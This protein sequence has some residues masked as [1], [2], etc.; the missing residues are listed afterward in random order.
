MALLLMQQMLLTNRRGYIIKVKKALSKA[1]VTL[2]SKFFEPTRENCIHP[3][4]LVFFDIMDKFFEYEDNLGKRAL[5]KAI[6]KM[7]IVEHEHDPYYRDRLNWVVEEL[8]EAVISGKWKP[9]E[10]GHP[11][12]LWN[13]PAPY[14]HYEGRDFQKLIKQ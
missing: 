9:R 13:E 14:G 7:V 10:T 12:R 1:I 2:A 4:T 3:N 11:N 8:V 6:W 5:F